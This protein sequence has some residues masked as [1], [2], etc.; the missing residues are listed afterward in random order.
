MMMR[1]VEKQHSSAMTSAMLGA[2]RDRYETR[3]EF[4]ELANCLGGAE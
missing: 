3:A 4:L 1:G 2:F